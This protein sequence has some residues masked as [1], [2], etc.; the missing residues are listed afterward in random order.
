[1]LAGGRQRDP[2]SLVE[3]LLR[4]SAEYVRLGPSERAW[5]KLSSELSTRPDLETKTILERAPDHALSV[6]ND[7]FEM[8][9]QQMTNDLAVERLFTVSLSFASICADRARVEDA[10]EP[11][12]KHI[13]LDRWVENLVDMANGALFAPVTQPLPVD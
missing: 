3:V 11:G 9:R 6:G 12:R 7:L 4:P 8:M 13:D 1:M 5:I 10:T 2:R